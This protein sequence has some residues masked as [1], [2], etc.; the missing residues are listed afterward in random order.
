MVTDVAGTYF[1]SGMLL[2]R[3]T[4]WRAI[5]LGV[6]VGLGIDTVVTILFGIGG[7]IFNIA[8][9]FFFFHYG[10]WFW[11]I[12]AGLAGGVVAG[13]LSTSGPKSGCWHGL[14]AGAIGGLGIA[15]STML[16]GVVLFTSV[17]DLHLSDLIETS[18]LFIAFYGLLTAIPSAIAGGIGAA[19]YGAGGSGGI[20]GIGR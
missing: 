2:E 15:I 1:V 3:M 14:L 9:F 5:G 16:I 19:V 10:S 11:T 6:L 4:R 13:F 7:M 8:V 12:V 17:G 18:F 20:A